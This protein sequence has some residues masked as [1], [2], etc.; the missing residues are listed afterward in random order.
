M[1]LMMILSAIAGAAIFFGGWYVGHVL[2]R[3]EAPEVSKKKLRKPRVPRCYV[4]V[5]D[6]GIEPVPKRRK[7]QSAPE[8]GTSVDLDNI[9]GVNVRV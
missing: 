3:A 8:H 6:E 9:P 5:P 2:D 1:Y 7:K 4:V